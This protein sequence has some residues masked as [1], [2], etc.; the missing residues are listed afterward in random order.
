ME[1]LETVEVDD[2]DRC[3]AVPHA[4]AV[5]QPPEPRLPRLLPGRSSAARSAPATRS[6]RCPPAARAAS[7]ASSPQDGDLDQAV[8]GQSVTLTLA[9]EIDISRGDVIAAAADALPEVADQFE[10]TLV[11]MSGR[12]DAAGAALPAEDRRQDRRPR[13]SPR[14]S[15][16]STSTRWSTWPPRRSS[17]TRSASAICSSTARSP[18]TPTSDNR[19]TGGFILIDRLTNDTVGRRHAA[20]RAAPLAQH[21]LAGARREQGGRAA[22]KGQKPVRP[23]VHGPVRRRQVDHRQP[24]REEAPRAGPAHLPARRRQRPPRPEQ[25]PRLHRRR[26]GREHPPRRRGREADGRRR[27]HRPRRRSSRR[28]APSGTW[29]A[30]WSPRGE[31]IEVFVD[32]PLGVAEQRDP[33]GLY[34]K[35]RRGELKNFTG[36]DSP[37]EAPEAPEIRIDT[38]RGAGG[39]GRAGF[40]TP[41]QKKKKNCKTTPPRPPFSAPGISPSLSFP[42]PMFPRPGRPG[43]APGLAGPLFS[44]RFQRTAPPTGD[45]G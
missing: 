5:G 26:P 29:R 41:K 7:R 39:L 30:R 22:L 9:D 19:D 1:H 8:A 14:R 36:I 12:A 32:T 2:V 31:F 16:R 25:G 6:R 44:T 4:G 27:P 42:T 45:R 11:W 3:S 43:L 37:Y 15:T 40:P 17:S 21:P 23:L 13:P 28:S 20:L 24:G 10:A 38:T 34:S 18:S 35:A 33:K